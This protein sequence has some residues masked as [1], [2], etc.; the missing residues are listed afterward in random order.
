MTAEQAA[1]INRLARAPV[2]TPPVPEIPKLPK[3]LRER[4]P[5][6]IAEIE[7]YDDAWEKFFK[8]PGS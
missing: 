5:D 6:K 2:G 1:K 8:R 3:F 7:A 4:H